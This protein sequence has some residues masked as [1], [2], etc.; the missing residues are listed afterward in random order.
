MGLDGELDN[1]NSSQEETSKRRLLYFLSNT[2]VTVE[3]YSAQG[4]QTADYNLNF[5][6]VVWVHQNLEDGPL[7]SYTAMH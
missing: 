6:I 7:Y 1:I 4:L 2:C 3:E 5:D